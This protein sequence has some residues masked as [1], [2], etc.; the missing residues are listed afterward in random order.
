MSLSKMTKS[1]QV[2][3]CYELEIAVE[4]ATFD[5]ACTAA[6]KKNAAGIKVP[7]F[8]PGNAPRALVEKMYGKFYLED[9]VNACIPEAYEGALAESKLEVVG[10]PEFDIVSVGDDGLVLKATVYVKPE[11][12]ITDYLGIEVEAQST[13]VSDEDV[14][15]EID[16]ARERNS[17][18]V[19]VTDRAAQDSDSVNINFAGSVDGVAFD[20]GTAENFDLR[21]GSGSFI[22][23]FEDQI[24]GH[25]IGD[26]FDVNVTFPADYH[27]ENL[28]GKAAVFAVKLNGIKETELPALD[29]EFAKD[30]SEFDTLDEYKADVRAKIQE[31]NEKAAEA[32]LEEK[33]MEA[34]IEK[35]VADIPEVMYAEETDNFYRDYENRMRMQGLDLATY[36]KYTGMN[37]AALRAQLRPQ[38]EKQVKLRLALEAIATRENVAVSE[39]DIAGEYK[40]I[41]EAYNM[42]EEKV[43]GFIARE[44]IEADMKVK[45]AMDLVKA[46]AKAKAPKKPKSTKAKST[47]AKTAKAE[48]EQA[49]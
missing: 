48:T 22:P 7:G 3:N 35:L 42:P 23:G 4:K 46:N 47:K 38:G 27:A 20:G 44:S 49:E 14:V 29:D 1:E 32:A 8:R 5:A 6:Y 10:Q 43:R 37:E 21:L 24:V 19:E 11:V 41:A 12:E 2:A 40:R 17:R 15:A 13:D 31:R 9:A 25:A 34:L 28:A 36:F 45:A 33:L 39:E 30:V 18:T 16:R 26:E